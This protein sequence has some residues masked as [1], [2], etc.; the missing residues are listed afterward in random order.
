M[1]YG[2]IIF[3][4]FDPKRKT[5]IERRAVEEKSFTKVVSIPD[6]RPELLDT[7]VITFNQRTLNYFCL[8]RRAK[9]VSASQQK[10]EFIEIVPLDHLPVPEFASNPAVRK[11]LRESEKLASFRAQPEVW[12]K[13]LILLKEKRPFAADSI[14]ELEAKRKEKFPLL[15]GNAFETVALEKDAV[16][17]AVDIFGLDRKKVLLIPD[18]PTE[19]APFLQDLGCS[20]L[21]EDTMISHDASIFPEW[22]S[23]M[24]YQVG[25][26]EFERGNQKL[27]I[28][29]VNRHPVERTLGVDLIYYHHVYQA[30][31]LVQ[32]K[33][34]SQENTQVWGFRPT[35][36]QCME[37]L[38]RMRAFNANTL[39][40]TQPNSL[41]EYRLN[42]EAFYFKL[43]QS[44]TYSPMSTDLIPGMYLPLDYWET[45]LQSPEIK[46]SH[47]GLRI[48]NENIYRHLNNTEFITLIKHGWIGSRR[49]RTEELTSII[50][51]LLS[52]D[53]SVIVAAS[54]K[55]KS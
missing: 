23:V 28:M 37:E 27:T 51:Q 31:V 29:N 15:D 24:Q 11:F 41:N 18:I 6:I 50:R 10:I 5:I 44:V 22:D 55:D 43:C 20:K 26:T 47:G 3:S 8:T 38:K 12:D 33:R 21:R 46:G 13:F 45:L 30:Y 16:G 48:T 53:H 35:E 42:P 17:L 4:V 25:A 1:E 19:P 39:D 9:K 32:Y 34:M 52:E 2:G 54:A 14:D 40:N 7:C 49:N 36:A